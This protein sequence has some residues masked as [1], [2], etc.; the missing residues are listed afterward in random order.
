MDQIVATFVAT[1]PEY[2]PTRLWQ[3]VLAI[4]I[5]GGLIRQ[6]GNVVTGLIHQLGH[7][8][9]GSRHNSWTALPLTVF[10]TKYTQTFLVDPYPS[11]LVLHRRP[12]KL[13]ALPRDFG[14]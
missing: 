1:S 9:T 7:L 6:P 13:L 2:L 12:T 14:T 11:R 3:G 5:Q 10:V 4:S 8:V